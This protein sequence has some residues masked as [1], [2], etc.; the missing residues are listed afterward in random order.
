MPKN[1]LS[2]NYGAPQILKE[3]D[4]G[5]HLPRVRA[6]EKESGRGQPH[7]KTSRNK[8]RVIE[9]VRGEICEL[10]FERGRTGSRQFG[11]NQFEYLYFK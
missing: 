6:S 9:L 4:F 10:A 2:G 5:H 8:L 3:G 7:S 1:L 11:I